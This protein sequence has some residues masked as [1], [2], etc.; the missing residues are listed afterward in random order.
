MAGPRI[1]RPLRTLDEEDLGRIDRCVAVGSLT[2]RAQ[3]ER[4]RRMG[5]ALFR[6]AGIRQ[7]DRIQPSL[8]PLK[9]CFEWEIQSHWPT[10]SP[11]TRVSKPGQR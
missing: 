6:R 7:V 10:L 3:E 8:D 11:S 4:D 2:S 9:E 5:Y 1:P